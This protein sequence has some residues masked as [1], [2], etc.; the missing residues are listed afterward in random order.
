MIK[1]GDAWQILSLPR[2]YTH[3]M[4]CGCEDVNLHGMKVVDIGIGLE[5]HWKTNPCEGGA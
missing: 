1:G 4:E 5:M 3:L 2:A